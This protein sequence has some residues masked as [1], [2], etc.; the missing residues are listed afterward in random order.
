MSFV[1][2]ILRKKVQREQI[3]RKNITIAKIFLA[4]ADNFQ[5]HHV[6]SAKFSN[7]RFFVSRSSLL[8]YFPSVEKG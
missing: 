8:K 4:L 7:P 5:L 3:M 2:V 6:L 1:A